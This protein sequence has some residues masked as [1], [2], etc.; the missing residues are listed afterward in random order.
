MMHRVQATRRLGIRLLAGLVL[1]AL[2]TV[3]AIG[4]GGQAVAAD[5]LELAALYA[6]GSESGVRV[7]I[8]VIRWSTDEERVS[9]AGALDP[10]APP[11]PPTEGDGRGRGGRGR[12]GRGSG[13]GQ[14]EPPTA[15]ER[16]TTAIT[17]AATIGH[18]FTEDSVVG[19]SIKYAYRDS[20]SPSGERIV[21]ATDRHFALAGTP[22]PSTEYPFTVIE[23]HL[24]SSG[25]GE[26][27]TSL[28]SAALFDRE[29]GTILLQD[30]DATPT[31]LEAVGTRE[32]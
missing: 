26:G 6:D 10:S 13:R 7:R 12:G 18:V 20:L 29:A 25:R 21:L 14:T 28:N 8:S 1:S 11:P 3:A 19:Y 22:P 17:E 9:L 31:T 2:C 24:D 5:T 4:A 27:K 32:E 23:I 16:I 15:L 30:Y